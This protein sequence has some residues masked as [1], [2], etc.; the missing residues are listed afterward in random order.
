MR[1]DCDAPYLLGGNGGIEL[2]LTRSI[3]FKG[4]AGIEPLPALKFD[5]KRDERRL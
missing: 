1:D 5:G 4:S 2:E 3:A